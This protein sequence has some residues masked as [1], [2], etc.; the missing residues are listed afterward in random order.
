MKKCSFCAEDIQDAAIVCKHC[1]RDVAAVGRA[2]LTTPP[3][4]QVAS[5]GGSGIGRILRLVVFT[6]LGGIVL[7]VVITVADYKTDGAVGRAIDNPSSIGG[8]VT[9]SQ[10]SQLGDGMS[11]QDAVRVLGGP[12]TEI[13][14]SDLAGT[15]TVMYQWDGAGMVANMNAMFQ[16]DRLV[17]KAQFGLR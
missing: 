16:N 4:A 12:G 6:I 7:V 1:G 13:S 15:V 3:P 11:Y 2:S 14:R 17:T 10:Y 8:G 9:L 5:G